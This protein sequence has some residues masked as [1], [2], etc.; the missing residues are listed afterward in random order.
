MPA[1]EI[2]KLFQDKNMKEEILFSG[3][4]CITD[5]DVK[6]IQSM[7]AIDIALEE[8][9]TQKWTEIQQ[10]AKENNSKIWDSE[11]YRLENLI[12]DR[13]KIILSVSIIPFSIRLAANSFT[14]EII[15]L[16]EKYRPMGMFFS[17]FLKTVDDFYVFIEKSKKLYTDK[18]ISFV[19]GVLSKTEF[20]LTQKSLSEAV[21]AEIEEEIGVVF[22]EKEIYLKSIYINE[23]LN[24]CLLLSIETIKTKEE[25]EKS[26]KSKDGEVASL[27]F[28]HI[29]Q[30]KDFTEK[31]P[32]KDAVK[33]KI[34]KIYE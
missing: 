30:L 25:L 5:V 15:E 26:F 14:K 12:R 33:F 11:L 4:I 31:L 16:G 9:F 7:R 27:K 22:D 17:C 19:G 13:D 18:I 20:D 24:C 3:N 29:S 10:K 6:E 1:L 23:T 32:S 8:K 34:A 21:I 2:W 28:V